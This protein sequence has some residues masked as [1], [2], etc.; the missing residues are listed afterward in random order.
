MDLAGKK[1]V[2]GLTGGIACYKAA[3]LTRALVKAGASV[4]VVMTDAATH[5]I[6][7]V[8]MQALSGQPVVTDQWDAR[9]ANNMPHIDLTRDADAIVIAPCS[10]DFIFKLAHGACDD[11]LS[12]LCVARPMTLPLMVAPAMNVEMWQNPATQRNVAQLKNDR[13]AVLGP[14]AGEQACGETGMGRMLEPAQLLEEIVAGFQPNLL[15][16]KSVLITAG[17]TFEPIDPVRGITNLSSGKMG[18]AIAR[19]AR[20]AG[21]DVTLVSGPTALDAPYG[22]RRI[23]VQTAEQMH[24]VVMSRVA[25]QHVFIAVA[26]VADWRV[27]NASAQKIKKNAEGKSPTL[28][29]EENADILAAVAALDKRPYCVGFAAESENLL[30]FGEAKRKKK[31]IPLLVGNI[32]PQTFGRDDNELML[33]DEKGHLPLP[34]ADK[35]TLARRLIAEI[36]ERLPD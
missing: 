22:V 28:E 35:Q 6:T 33:F 30:E 1:I 7:P 16:G 20:E 8:T 11:L 3:E 2:L 29:F 24:D 5:F 14:D 19:A 18:Y 12:T 26:A 9:I 25:S 4:Q 17:P 13:I 15:V 23:G 21:A 32:G 10:A 31:N 36:A 34:R 27:K